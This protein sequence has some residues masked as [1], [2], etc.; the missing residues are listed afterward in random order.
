[1]LHFSCHLS[2]PSRE[3]L[4][5]LDLLLSLSFSIF[6]LRLPHFTFPSSP[7]VFFHSDYFSYKLISNLFSPKKFIRDI[8]PS[9]VTC[10]DI[11]QQCSIYLI[12][13]F[14][15]PENIV[16]LWIFLF[17][18]FSS[19]TF[20]SFSVV[21]PVLSTLLFQVFP[22]QKLRYT[23]LLLSQ[24][25]SNYFTAVYT[26]IKCVYSLLVWPLEALPFLVSSTFFLSRY[27]LR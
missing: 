14:A 7:P 8:S 2:F 27:F 26:K 1:M 3:Y 19:T 6:S 10:I 9:P 16:L 22:L 21:F 5:S 13:Y 18:F 15:L 25:W 23:I 24:L 17:N 12:N 20:T 11:L 4:S